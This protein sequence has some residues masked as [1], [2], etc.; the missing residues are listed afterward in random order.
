MVKVLPR[1]DE[2]G[3]EHELTARAQARGYFSRTRTSASARPSPVTC[4]RAPPS[5]W[6]SATGIP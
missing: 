4:T 3:P 1:R 6:W 2:I 5:I